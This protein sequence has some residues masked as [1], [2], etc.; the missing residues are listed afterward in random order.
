M[1]ALNKRS[2][3]RGFTLVELLVVIGILVILGGLAFP[4]FSM[5]MA[6]AR[7]AK[8][9]SNLRSIGAAM[10]TFAGDNNGNL[11]ESGGTIYHTGGPN[12]PTVDATTGLNSWTEQLEPYLGTSSFNG[13]TP[14]VNPIFQ[15]PDWQNVVSSSSGQPLSP[16]SNSC[17]YYSYFN[18]S[19]AAGGGNGGYGAVNLL[20]IHAPNAHIIAGDIAFNGYQMLDAD[21]DD[22]GTNN[23]AFAGTTIRLHGGS[24]NLVFADGHG[25]NAKSYDPTSMT[26][27][28]AGIEPT[29]AYT[30]FP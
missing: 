30:D 6:H 20:R 12:S 18:G 16:G 17:K 11:P 10:I 22:Y 28:Y 3:C 8:C 27:H 19:H 4:A 14:A 29:K 9:S 5:A 26:T 13:T 7:T 15:C 23:P 2:S 24:V 21:P 25:E 1:I